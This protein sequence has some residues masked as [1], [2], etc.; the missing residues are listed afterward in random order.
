MGPRLL[1]QFKAPRNDRKKSAIDMYRMERKE[2][3][4]AKGLKT[5]LKPESGKFDLVAWNAAM[6]G[7]FEKL[8]DEE[9]ARFQAQADE[10]NTTK[11]EAAK[12]EGGDEDNIRR[13]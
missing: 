1:Q 8:T 5:F 7:D 4:K 9:K 10:M 12:A 2:E 11:A 3:R 13:S 6:E